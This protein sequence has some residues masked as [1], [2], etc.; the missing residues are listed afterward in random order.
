MNGGI[1]IHGVTALAAVFAHRC[2][3]SCYFF[4]RIRSPPIPVWNLEIFSISDWRTFIN[5]KRIVIGDIVL[6][7][8]SRQKY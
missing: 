7:G 2:R 5:S 1:L 8:V 4:V 6:Y 3:D